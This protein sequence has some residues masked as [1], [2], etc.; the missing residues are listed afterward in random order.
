MGFLKKTDSNESTNN[1]G[2]TRFANEAAYRNCVIK[3]LRRIE[4]ALEEIDPDLVECS[5]SQGALT[6]QFSDSTKC[7]L[8][9]QPSVQQ[10]WLAA[11]SQGIAHHFDWDSKKQQWLDDKKGTIEL[12]DFLKKLI[13][14]QVRVEMDW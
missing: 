8:S 11:A 5:L 9:A 10:V 14:N 13:W 6:L 12:F 4:E 3:T 7:I 1:P 2:S